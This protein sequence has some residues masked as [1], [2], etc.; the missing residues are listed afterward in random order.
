MAARVR[1]SFHHSTRL[2]QTHQREAQRGR[3]GFPE[4]YFSESGTSCGT[5]ATLTKGQ[6]RGRGSRQGRAQPQTPAGRLARDR[7][8]SEGRWWHPVSRSRETR[9]PW[10]SEGK[11]MSS[12]AVSGTGNK[13]RRP[14]GHC[15][16]TP[17][18]PWGLRP[19]APGAQGTWGQAARMQT[20]FYVWNRHKNSVPSRSPSVMTPLEWR[21]QD[22]VVTQLGSG[23]QRHSPGSGDPGMPHGDPALHP[24]AP[25]SRFPPGQRNH[26]RLRCRRGFVTSLPPPGFAS[27]IPLSKYSLNSLHRFKFLPSCKTHHDDDDNSKALCVLQPISPLREPHAVAP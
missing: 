22:G 7:R 13:P 21:L 25:P 8:G 9:S 16:V 14:P 2:P 19:A 6:A 24:R 18:S 10:P 27:G 5:R 20:R 4:A 3:R 15:A 23:T 26:P 11:K 17:S 12:V 1:Q